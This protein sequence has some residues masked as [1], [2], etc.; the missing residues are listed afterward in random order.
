MDGEKGKRKEEVKER[1]DREG[2]GEWTEN[3]QE[4]RGGKEG[5]IYR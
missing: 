2:Y 3:G 1:A 5:I 4:K